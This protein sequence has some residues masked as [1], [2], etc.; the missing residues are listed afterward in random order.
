MTNAP[1][2]NA[3]KPFDEN[4]LDFNMRDL[5]PIQG[6]AKIKARFYG[7]I[8]VGKV[9]TLRMIARNKNT[10]YLPFW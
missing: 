1:V 8:P 3:I 10:L 6:I 9:H 2:P 5:V 7:L 4:T